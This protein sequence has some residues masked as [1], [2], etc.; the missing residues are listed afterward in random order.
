LLRVLLNRVLPTDR[1]TLGVVV[2]DSIRDVVVG[3]L[4]GALTPLA[5]VAYSVAA[6]CM[7]QEYPHHCPVVLTS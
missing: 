6:S 5:G 2:G 3:S 1:M 4:K 7:P